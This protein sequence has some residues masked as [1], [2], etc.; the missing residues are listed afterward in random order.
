[1]ASSY[2]GRARA[3]RT[4]AEICGGTA[5]KARS[6][7]AFFIVNGVSLADISEY[8]AHFSRNYER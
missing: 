1:V 8:H 6:V 5:K 3:A 2:S 4:S 7:K